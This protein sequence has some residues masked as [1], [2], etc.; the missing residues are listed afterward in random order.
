MK[1]RTTGG[2]LWLAIFMAGT[3]SLERSLGDERED[4]CWDALRMYPVAPAVVFMAKTLFNFITLVG[5]A[6]V[7]IPL[8]VV[9]ADAPLLARPI[10]MLAIV[11]LANLGLA[12]IGTLM[13][14][15]TSGMRRRGNQIALLL[16][17]LVLPVVLAAGEATRLLIAGDLSDPFWRWLQLLAAFDLM[18]CTL[19]VLIFDFVMED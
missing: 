15:L 1:Q 3:M 18:F 10:A 16:L 17:P 14:A 12:A 11:V 2:L 9:L 19:G 6:A 13:S 7:M 8:F 5:V 4:G